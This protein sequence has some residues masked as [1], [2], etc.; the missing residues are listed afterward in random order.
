MRTG[1]STSLQHSCTVGPIQLSP[2]GIE[3][4]EPALRSLKYAH[5][6]VESKNFGENGELWS[7]KE[8]FSLTVFSLGTVAHTLVQ[9]VFSKQM[10]II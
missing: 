7:Q 3:Q 4:S 10:K 5:L 1:S 9:Q 6:A 2:L 8:R